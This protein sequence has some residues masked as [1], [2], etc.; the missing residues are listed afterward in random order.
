[1]HSFDKFIIGDAADL[2]DTDFACMVSTTG[3]VNFLINYNDTTKALTLFRD[4]NDPFLKF[5]QFGDVFYGKNGTDLNLCK[6]EGF[7]Y[8][9]DPA[10]DLKSLANS[11]AT[12][13]L[14]HKEGALPD[15]KLYLRTFDEGIINVQWTYWTKPTQGKRQ[16]LPVP[17]L[18]VNTTRSA[19]NASAI[20]NFV[21][22]TR[23]PF[24]IKIVNTPEST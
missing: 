12:I 22:I 7:E 1:M 6:L 2:K 15:L 20:G 19:K 11:E 17:D 10:D 9:V 24:T 14:I 3:I 5:S 18:L 4:I 23:N 21:K 13:K 8:M 16:H